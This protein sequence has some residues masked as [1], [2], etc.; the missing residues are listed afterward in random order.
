MGRSLKI[1]K[2]NPDV[3]GPDD[4]VDAGYNNLY[5][6]VGGNTG[7]SNVGARPQITCSIRLP[8]RP[9]SLGSIIRQK[10][11]RKFLV[12]EL[13]DPTQQGTCVLVNKA[14]G[15]LL[16]G[17]MSISLTTFSN[18]AQFL[19]ALRNHYGY[20]FN[21]TGYILQFAS[22]GAAAA[23]PP[24]SIYTIATIAGN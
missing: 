10:G 13:I 4:L 6:V 14:Q 7:Q 2:T 11:T 3:S 23:A 17:E 1:R 8:G 19:A 12:Q 22:A 18:G 16:P 21:G 5:G 20:D 24:G 9:P 15:A